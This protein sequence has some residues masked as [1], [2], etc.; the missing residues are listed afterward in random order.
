MQLAAQNDAATHDRPK[1]GR[2]RPQRTPLVKGKCFRRNRQRWEPP[3]ELRTACAS[4]GT[5]H[6]P[7]REI[8]RRVTLL[9]PAP[10]SHLTQ[11][12]LTAPH[13]RLFTGANPKTKQKETNATTTKETYTKQWRN[14]RNIYQTMTQVPRPK[15]QMYTSSKMH[16]KFIHIYSSRCSIL[17]K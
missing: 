15:G 1:N 8:L 12:Y 3:F 10:T 14:E 16:A 11:L 9:V 2:A 6:L 13:D 5:Q 4:G 7:R 17:K